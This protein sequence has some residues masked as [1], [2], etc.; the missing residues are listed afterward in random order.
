MHV[1]S[2]WH[3]THQNFFYFF[4]LAIYKK[5][6]L[7]IEILL[8]SEMVTTYISCYA[9]SKLFSIIISTKENIHENNHTPLFH[10]IYFEVF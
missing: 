3:G 6:L 1:N 9:Y 8:Y 4:E 2:H 5:I 7:H 10:V